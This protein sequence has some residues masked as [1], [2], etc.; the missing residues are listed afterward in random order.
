MMDNEIKILRKQL[1]TALLEK[2]NMND[3]I[4]F[5]KTCPKTEC[6]SCDG[7]LSEEWT[8]EAVTNGH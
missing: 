3:A 4:E 7:I 5:C 6:V 8:G 1:A 2:G